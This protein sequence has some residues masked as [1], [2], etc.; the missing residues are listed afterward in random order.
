MPSYP[1]A[2]CLTVGCPGRAVPGGRGRCERCRRTTRE[3]GYGVPHERARE[4]LLA[5]LPAPCGYGCGRLLL[6]D[7]DWAAAHRVDGNPAAGY[8]ASC[9][10][11]NER[12]KGTGRGGHRSPKDSH[13][14]GDPRAGILPLAVR[15]HGGY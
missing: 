1:A 3:R 2:A 11:C 14:I 15:N 5:T 12:A 8:L 10:T 7:G 9:R 6:P 13:P 4:T